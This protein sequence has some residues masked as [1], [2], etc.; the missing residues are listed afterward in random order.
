MRYVLKQKLVSLGNNFM[1]RNGN[2]RDA[3]RVTGSLLGIGEKLSFQDVA[4]KEL[5]YIEQRVVRRSNSY[6]VRREGRYLADVKRDDPSFFQHRFRIEV[7]ESA[8]LDATADFLDRKYVIRRA[9]SEIM[10]MSKRWFRPSETYAIEIDDREAD[11]VLLLAIAVVIERACRK[12][13]N[14]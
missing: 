10:T 14:R 11:P 6:Q 4:G 7:R 1:I 8:D 9:G 3:F 12:L 2:G 5:A 13:Q